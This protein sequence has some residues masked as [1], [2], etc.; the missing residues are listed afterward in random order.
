M[1]R[2]PIRSTIGGMPVKS[3][4]PKKMRLPKRGL[5][6]VYFGDGKGKTTAALGAVL[7]AA[8]SGWKC[9]VLQFIK[10]AWP[11]GE[12][13]AIGKYLKET[14]KISAGGKGFVKIMGDKLPESEHK[15]AARAA[16]SRARTLANARALDLLVLDELLDAV[17]L[18]FV[19][20]REV[21]TLIRGRRRGLHIIIT[22][23]KRFTRIFAAADIVTE[24]RKV[25]HP[26]DK[27][28]IAVRGLDY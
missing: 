1:T 22:G 19:A 21:I 24:M 23:H 15:K 8:G 9:E 20:E 6:A 27:G 14:A 12:R 11:L 18:G 26:F 5:A 3:K 7:R 4:T 25:K 16:F 17:E 10:G 28:F 2:T 13:D